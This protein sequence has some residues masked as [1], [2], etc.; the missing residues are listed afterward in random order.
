MASDDLVLHDVTRP[1]YP[2]LGGDKEN[3]HHLS[4]AAKSGRTIR[5]NICSGPVSH[6][7][8]PSPY[9]YDGG[10]RGRLTSPTKKV[11]KLNDI[12]GDLLDFALRV[13]IRRGD[14]TEGGI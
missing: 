11:I 4:T 6:P 7:G 2:R 9:I 8:T 14:T 12:Y 10:L 5:C 1:A 13:G 3:P